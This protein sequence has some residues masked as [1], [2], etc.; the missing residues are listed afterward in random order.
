MR[1][2]PAEVHSLPLPAALL[3]ADG[4]VWSATPEWQGRRAGS[5]LYR[6]GEGSSLR[7]SPR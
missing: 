5:L 3:M 4:Q 2:D 7:I 1:I 6:V